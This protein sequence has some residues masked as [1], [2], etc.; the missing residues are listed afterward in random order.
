VP[1]SDY[2]S[3]TTG[4][5]DGLTGRRYLGLRVGSRVSDR[6]A[7]YA[8]RKCPEPATAGGRHLALSVGTRSSVSVVAH[9]NATAVAGARHLGL[10][11][12]RR[13][14]VNVEAVDPCLSVA[15]VVTS[16]GPCTTL[17]R[18]MYL[19]ML[20]PTGTCVSNDYWGLLAP[21]IGVSIKI[22]YRQPKYFPYPTCPGVIGGQWLSSP[23]GVYP[24]DDSRNTALCTNPGDS[25]LI[26]PSTGPY[27]GRPF[28]LW[29]Q[30]VC[31]SA[32]VVGQCF[33]KGAA[34]IY[35]VPCAGGPG[36]VPNYSILWGGCVTSDSSPFTGDA[37]VIDCATPH[38]RWNGKNVE[39]HVG[40]IGIIY[41]STIDVEL[42]P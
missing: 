1:L 42:L 20:N 25:P 22:T 9:P 15:P 29:G 39:A 10:T 32:A 27:A 40:G 13:S 31:P 23:A 4:A 38:I 24:G 16:C 2:V 36:D 17:P 26:V 35:L 30:Y 33:C 18:V 12:A 11:V 41:C 14:G 3:S 7:I 28:R 5:A 6:R 34:L 37:S 19:T 8:V 21:C